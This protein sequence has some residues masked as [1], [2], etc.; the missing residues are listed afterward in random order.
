MTFTS[1]RHIDNDQ[2]CI[3]CYAVMLELRQNLIGPEAF[4]AQL[5]RQ[6][7]QGYRLLAAW[8]GEEIVALAGYRFQENLLYGRFVYIDDLVVGAGVRSQG[9]GRRLIEAVREEAKRLRC[10]RLVL[11]TGLSNAF[12]QRFYFRQGLLATGL[13]FVEAVD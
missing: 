6:S 9:L 13:H 2:D 4:V 8:Q 1:L 7:E 12:A 10:D 3:A 11:D 5:R